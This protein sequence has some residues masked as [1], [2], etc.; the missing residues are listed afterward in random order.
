[1]VGP[2]HQ[3]VSNCSYAGMRGTRVLAFILSNIQ[4]ETCYL[5]WYFYVQF[6]IE[7]K[8]VHLFTF[9]KDVLDKKKFN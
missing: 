6:S 4:S 9:F 8:Y 7:L 5:I 3:Q 2:A 1:M